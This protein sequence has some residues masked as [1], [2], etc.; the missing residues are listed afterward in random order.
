[1]ASFQVNISIDKLKKAKNK[2][3]SKNVLADTSWLLFNGEENQDKVVYIFK[4][5]NNEFL[6]SVNGDIQ[7]GK[8]EF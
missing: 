3:L 4:S 7:V 6:L 5:K 1:M 8:W 2:Y